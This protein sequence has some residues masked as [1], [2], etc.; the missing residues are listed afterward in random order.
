MRELGDE[1]AR[2]VLKKLQDYFPSDGYLLSWELVDYIESL[3]YYIETEEYI[4]VHAGL[5]LAP[6]GSILPLA[7]QKE[8]ALVFDRRFKEPSVVPAT[9][10][11]VLF[12]HTPCSYDG[13]S[14][15]IKTIRPGKS[16]RSSVF[17]DYVKIRLDT[18]VALTGT[19]GCL[20][21]EDMREF[22]VRELSE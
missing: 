13:A 1:N 14:G 16:P 9:D 6:D 7:T 12:G 8:N 3:P 19:V 21:K 5:S 15:F 4:C 11:V 22:F 17:S 10:K 18:G 20:R 2:G